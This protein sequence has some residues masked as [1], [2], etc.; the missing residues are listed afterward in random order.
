MEFPGGTD[1][2]EMTL[3]G[4]DDGTVTSV[5]GKSNPHTTTGL[6]NLPE[7]GTVG[8]EL[9]ASSTQTGVNWITY[10][11][12]TELERNSVSAGDFGFHSADG[13]THTGDD[14]A[15][16]VDDEVTVEF[17]KDDGAHVGD[18]ARVFAEDG[19]VADRAGHDNIVGVLG[20]NTTAP[21]L[22]GADQLSDT[23]VQFHFD[24]AVS[25]IDPDRFVIHGDS[26][27]RYEGDTY[28]LDDDS[29]TVPVVFQDLSASPTA[30]TSPPSNPTRP[31]PTPAPAPRPPPA[32]SAWATSTTPPR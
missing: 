31:L 14:I 21:D 10:Q 1:L 16:L 18:V 22:T 27:Q 5:D 17:D 32:P 6:G 19:A 7:G 23:A 30:P 28:T 4:A 29:Q 24:D 13:V 25:D 3:I 15:Q 26:G 8:P 11:F 2:H 12:D 20:G 9:Q